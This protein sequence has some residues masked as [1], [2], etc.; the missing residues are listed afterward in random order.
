MRGELTVLAAMEPPTDIGLIAKP[1]R[2]KHLSS[3][4]LLHRRT[5]FKRLDKVGKEV[6]KAVA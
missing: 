5:A 4:P 2:C 3:P 6:R 1:R